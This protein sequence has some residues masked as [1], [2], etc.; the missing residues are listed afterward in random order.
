MDPDLIAD[1]RP[2]LSTDELLQL[3]GSDYEDEE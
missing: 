1:I 3:L 2:N